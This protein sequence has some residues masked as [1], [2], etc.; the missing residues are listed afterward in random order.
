MKKIIL[1]LLLSEL[2]YGCSIYTAANAPPSVD[3]KKVHVN[4]TRA[5]TISILGVPKLT[6]NNQKTDTFEFLD[7]IH[8][9]SKA[10][11]ILYLAGDIFTVGLSELIFYPIEANAF[12]GKQCRGV[13]SYNANDR[14][15]SYDILNSDGERL[16]ASGEKLISSNAKT[17]EMNQAVVKQPIS[18]NTNTPVTNQSVQTPPAPSYQPVVQPQVV[19][20]PVQPVVQ[21]TAPTYETYQQPQVEH[22]GKDL[23]GCLSLVDNAAIAKCVRGK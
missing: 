9:A 8:G 19:Q 10:R 22:P 1:V 4:A 23:R 14:V 3:Y 6:D 21:E 5:E 20:Q 11:I 13:V 18:Y 17:P 7:G 2:L 16:W 15:I 12:D